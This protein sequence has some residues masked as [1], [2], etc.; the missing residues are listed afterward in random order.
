MRTAHSHGGRVPRHPA[1]QLVSA[2]K[3]RAE[4]FYTRI[5][6]LAREHIPEYYFLLA[7]RKFEQRDLSLGVD[8]LCPAVTSRAI[9]IAP[10]FFAVVSPQPKRTELSCWRDFQGTRASSA[11]VSFEGGL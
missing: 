10:E 9:T 8:G 1:P 5:S 3:P 2:A 7:A 11:F 4:S 6:S